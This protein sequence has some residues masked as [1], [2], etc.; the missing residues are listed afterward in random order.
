MIL[1]VMVW[2]ALFL[3]HRF[4]GPFERLE[5]ELDR[6]TK[7]ADYSRRITLRKKDDLKPI[8]DKLNALLD[9]IQRKAR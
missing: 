8:A 4:I 6:M 5:R 2:W 9:A 1:A 3:S 7:S